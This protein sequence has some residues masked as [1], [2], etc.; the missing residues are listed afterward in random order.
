MATNSGCSGCGVRRP[1]VEGLRAERSITA[2]PECSRLNGEI[3]GFE[4]AHP[5]LVRRCH[6]MTVDA[7]GAQ[8]PG[9]P[10]R[11]IRVAYSLV[12]LHLALDLGLSGTEVRNAHARM[13][14]PTSTWPPFGRPEGFAAVTILDVARDGA[15]CDSPEGHASA[16][17]TWATAVWAWWQESHRDVEQLTQSLLG[18]WLRSR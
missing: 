12:G 7:Y 4:L 13:G 8:H 17:L 3:A 6:Q 9:S 5:W 10:T 2:S 11:P 1:Q 14:K 16:V 15:W 18:D